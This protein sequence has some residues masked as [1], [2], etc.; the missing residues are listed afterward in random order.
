MPVQAPKSERYSL[1]FR[2]HSAR[3]QIVVENPHGVT[4][5]VASVEVDGQRLA[6][7]AEIALLDDAA[8]HQVRVSLG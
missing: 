1:A 6:P 8:T 2:Y 3:Y 5:G 7:G 4:H